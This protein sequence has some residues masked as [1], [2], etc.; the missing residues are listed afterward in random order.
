MVQHDTE[1]KPPK[2]PLFRLGFPVLSRRHLRLLVVLAILSAA[3][4]LVLLH[5]GYDLSRSIAVP[6]FL[7]LAVWRTAPQGWKRYI[8]LTAIVWLLFILIGSL[9]LAL[10]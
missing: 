5:Q 6:F 4:C 7:L 3:Y 8:W 9:W 2:T 1:R 10:A